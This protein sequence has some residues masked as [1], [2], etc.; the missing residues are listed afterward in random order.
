MKGTHIESYRFPILQTTQRVKI[1]WKYP[2]GFKDLMIPMFSE[3]PA[4]DLFFSVLEF[5]EGSSGSETLV[6]LGG[7][8]NRW[9][10]R[11]DSPLEMGLSEL[12]VRIS[13]TTRWLQLPA[14]K[15]VKPRGTVVLLFTLYF[16]KIISV[17][18]YYFSELDWQK[19]F[20]KLKDLWG[21]SS[22]I[23]ILGIKNV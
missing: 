3:K 9:Q 12:E 15:G 13:V 5:P 23:F 20:I 4:R 19:Q 6:G 2:S 10:P 11:E 7:M 22:L 8:G 21:S 14:K 18:E 17:W 1:K 16:G